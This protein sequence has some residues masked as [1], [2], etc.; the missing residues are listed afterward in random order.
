MRR[1]LKTVQKR[2]VIFCFSHDGEEEGFIQ[3][4]VVE[5]GGMALVGG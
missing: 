5:V 2:V 1:R 4:G 3:A